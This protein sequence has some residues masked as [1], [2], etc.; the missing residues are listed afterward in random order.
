[1]NRAGSTIIASGSGDKH[2]RAR[3]RAEPADA[4]RHELVDGDLCGQERGIIGIGRAALAAHEGIRDGGGRLDDEA[5]MVRNLRRMA[6]V[7]R[8]RQRRVERAVDRHA[9]QKRMRAVGG[10]AVAGEFGVRILVAI[11]DAAP[12]RKRPG[13]VPR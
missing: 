3:F 11:D 5:E 8:E 6:R 12:A 10:K 4:G 9:A 1:M 13:H 7:F 2:E